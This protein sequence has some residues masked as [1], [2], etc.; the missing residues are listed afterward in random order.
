MIAGVYVI[1]SCWVACGT[2]L[3]SPALHGNCVTSVFG[4][5]KIRGL[6]EIRLISCW[7]QENRHVKLDWSTDRILNLSI[8]WAFNDCSHLSIFTFFES[9]FLYLLVTWLIF[10]LIQC[11]ETHMH[12]I[13]TKAT[14]KSHKGL[15]CREIIQSG[16][17]ENL[18]DELVECAIGSSRCAPMSL[19]QR[20]VHWRRRRRRHSRRLVSDSLPEPRC[21][22]V[23]FRFD[24]IVLFINFYSGSAW[25]L[26]F[27]IT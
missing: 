25:I 26:E 13:E 17:R 21:T 12:R 19:G 27:G 16:V 9:N 20:S 5:L 10:S 8:W 22:N 2:G 15:E 18:E 24:S 23:V 1:N 14:S 3:M 7:R 11:P 4:R 6:I